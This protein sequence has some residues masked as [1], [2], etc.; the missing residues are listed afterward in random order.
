MNPQTDADKVRLDQ[1][2]HRIIGCAFEVSNILGSGYLEKVYENA[3][4]HELLQAGMEVKQQEPLKVR[5]KGVI[6]GD[7]IADLI[8]ENE[9]IIELKAVKEFN[10]VHLAQCLNYL[11]TT[12]LRL[13]LLINFGNPKVEIKR[14][15]RNY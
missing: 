8:I 4:A 12:G 9:V 3:L 5:Y 11:K 10:D 14:V 7:Y 6:A 13:C 2:T 15:V 1:I